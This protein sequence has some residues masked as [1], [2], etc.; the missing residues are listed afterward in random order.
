MTATLT[1][2]AAAGLAFLAP[3]IVR[4]AYGEKWLPMVSALQ[5]LCLHGLLRS[6]ETTSG[7]L[8]M[9]TGKPKY[10]FYKHLLGIGVIIITIVAL[11]RAW[12]IVGTSLS[13]SLGMAATSLAAFYLTRK[14]VAL[15]LPTL[16]VQIGPA[17]C[18]SLAMI[19]GLHGLRTVFPVAGVGQLCMVVLAGM[20]FYSLSLVLLDRQLLPQMLASVRQK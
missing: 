6:L 1:V 15:S 14:I 13:V 11:T 3:D 10:D 18:A 12:G 20:L 8:F 17:C 2:P 7:P 16:V 9:A 19:V 5:V 4:V